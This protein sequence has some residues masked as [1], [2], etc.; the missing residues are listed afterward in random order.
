MNY[1]GPGQGGGVD[2]NIERWRGQV[3]GAEHSETI[4]ASGNLGRLLEDRGRFDEAQQIYATALAASRKAHPEP[5]V[6][7]ANLLFDLGRLAVLRKQYAE[8]PST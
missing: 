6:E 4:E 5:H 7:V 8:A 3:L 1:F 2:A